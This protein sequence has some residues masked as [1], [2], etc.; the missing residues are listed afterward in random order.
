MTKV[1]IKNKI[2]AT[3][4]FSDLPDFSYFQ[5]E[6]Y[7]WIKVLGDDFHNCISLTGGLTGLKGWLNPKDQVVPIAEINLE[8]VKYGQN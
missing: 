5:N 8:V 7:I 4:N 6:N 3:I 1:N 2:L